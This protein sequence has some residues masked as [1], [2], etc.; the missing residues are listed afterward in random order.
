MRLTAKKAVELSIELWAWLAET[1]R[2]KKEW[3]GWKHNGGEHETVAILC[4]LCEYNTRREERN[5]FSVNNLDC[6][7]CPYHAKYGDCDDDEGQ[8]PYAK[9]VDAENEIDKKNY[10][11]QFL[12][13]LK[14]ILRGVK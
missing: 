4:F 12:E 13:Q 1:G 14:E 5:Q 8:S 7:F 6:E 10:A 3:P 11:K 2:E 9:W